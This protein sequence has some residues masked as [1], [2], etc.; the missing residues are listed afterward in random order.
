MSVLNHGFVPAA[1][2]LIFPEICM[3]CHADLSAASGLCSC[4]EERMEPLPTERCAGCGG[5]LDTVVELCRECLPMKRHWEL[6]VSCYGF[7][8]AA[9]EAVLR[10]KYSGDT[11]LASLLGAVMAENWQAYGHAKAEAVTA[12]PLHWFKELRRGFNQSQLLAEH[13]GCHLDLPAPK[14]LR[15]TRWT[16]SQAGLNL[17]RRRRNLRRAFAAGNG[18]T[19]PEHVILVDDVLTT[20]ST[21]AACTRALRKA[22][23]LQVSVLSVARG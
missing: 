15:R 1:D 9:R 7:H 21:L 16:R 5:R 12:V 10:F 6:A 20:G 11:A 22:G 2:A 17:A 3:L 23:A 14:L 4:C 13:V 8:G 19:V 18:V